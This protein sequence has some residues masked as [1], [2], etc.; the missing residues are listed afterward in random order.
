MKNYYL[1][2]EERYKKVHSEGLLWFS[3]NP[4]PELLD[5]IEY[6]HISAGDEICEIGCG[7]GR[8]AL[9][10]SEMGFN[11]TAVDVSETAI[12]KCKEIA[13][14]KGLNVNFI[15][16]DAL[17]LNK[18]IKAKYKWVY[19]IATL[20]ML[21]NDIDREKFLN[22][23]HELLQPEGRLLLIS[24]GDG[25]S[26]IKTDISDAFELQER[27]HMYTGKKLLVAGTSYRRINWCNHKNELEK[28]GFVI[29]RAINSENMEYGSCMTVYLIKN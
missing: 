18:T 20:H 10:L 4:T 26:E 17:C 12:E 21:V 3:D 15:I 29:E 8:D 7:E 5:W 9:Y 16:A 1:A 24:M 2:Y 28:S 11:V 27:N 19:S 14:S 13:R 23:V 6:N 22:S 25:V